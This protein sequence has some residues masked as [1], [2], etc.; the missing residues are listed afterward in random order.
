MFL[1]LLLQASSQRPTSLTTAP[2]WRSSPHGPAPSSQ[3]STCCWCPLPSSTT[4]WLKSTI[5]KTQLHLRGP[6]TPRTV[7]SQTSSTCWICAAFRSQLGFCVW[8]TARRRQQRAP[9]R[10]AQGGWRQA[11]DHSLWCCRLGLR[12]WQALGGMSGCGVLL[13][14]WRQQLGWAV[15]RRGTGL[16]LWWFEAQWRAWWCVE[17]QAVHLANACLYGVGGCPK[18]HLEAAAGLAVGQRGT[19]LLLWWCEAQWRA[20][21]PLQQAP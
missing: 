14:G 1:N 18:G 10:H 11:G 8:I 2:A 15:G 6:L 7:A 9:G 21:R 16:P 4:W 20:W 5:Q 12:C 19:G 13:S 17:T 3:S